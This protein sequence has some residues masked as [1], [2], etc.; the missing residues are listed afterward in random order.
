MNRYLNFCLLI[1]CLFLC[2]CRTLKESDFAIR[3]S[4]LTIIPPLEGTVDLNNLKENISFGTVKLSGYYNGILK[5]HHDFDSIRIFIE[6][7]YFSKRAQRIDPDFYFTKTEYKPDERVN[8]MIKLFSKEVKKSSSKGDSLKI[9]T[10]Q[11]E[12][13]AFNEKKYTWLTVIS[14]ITL[15]IPNLIG[16]PLNRINTTLDI[17]VTIFTNSNQSIGK[18]KASGNGIAYTAMYWGYGEDANRKSAIMAFNNAMTSIKEQI[19]N[20]KNQL[21]SD[22]I[23]K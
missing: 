11:L 6:D 8:D 18:F 10:I 20:N 4:L 5:V 9:G 12:I 17:Q 7:P 13:L 15:F 14:G 1:S 22:L 2:N 16:M 23:K 19:K 21:I 3:E